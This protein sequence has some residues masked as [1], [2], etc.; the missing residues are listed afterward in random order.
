MSITA[1]VLAA[2]PELAAREDLIRELQAEVA[3]LRAGVVEPEPIAVLR[4]QRDAAL[5]LLA[6]V[7]AILRR[8]GGFR[9]PRQQATIR[10][11]NAVLVENGRGVR[12]TPAL[13]V[14]RP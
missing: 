4:A 10:E 13:W 11:A 3:R 2:L 7:V 8:D 5:D 12:D 6:R 9:T 1:A 14:D